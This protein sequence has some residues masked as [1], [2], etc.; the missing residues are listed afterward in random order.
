MINSEAFR[1]GY[2]AYQNGEDVW[3]NEYEEG[4]E[5]GDWRQGWL[6]AAEAHEREADS[7]ERDKVMDDPRHGQAR[8]IN[9]RIG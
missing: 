9:R 3:Q 7:N 5:A 1:N 8:D 2:A 6:A 4:E